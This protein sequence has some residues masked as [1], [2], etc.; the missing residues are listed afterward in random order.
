MIRDAVS[1]LLDNG[2][3]YRAGYN[4]GLRDAVKAISGLEGVKYIAYKGRYIDTI[5]SEV[6]EEMEM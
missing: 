4:Q 1:L 5:A 3:Q 6:I 2:D